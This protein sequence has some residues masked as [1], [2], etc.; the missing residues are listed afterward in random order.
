MSGVRTPRPQYRPTQPHFLIS[1][2]STQA[3]GRESCPRLFHVD[4]LCIERGRGMLSQSI[5]L[6]YTL[7]QFGR[8]RGIGA[9][10]TCPECDLVPQELTTHTSR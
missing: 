8:D 1:A 6:F 3:S 5:T 2:H 7:A 10:T 9:D 4:V